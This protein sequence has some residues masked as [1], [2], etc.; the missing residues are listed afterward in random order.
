MEKQARVKRLLLARIVLV[1]IGV[2]VWGYGFRIDD[3]RIRLAGILALAVSL[4]LRLVPRRW[5]EKRD[6]SLH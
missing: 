5:L 1:G 6:E 2:A 3:S 4:L